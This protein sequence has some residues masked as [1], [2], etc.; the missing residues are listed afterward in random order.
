M[1][2]VYLGNYDGYDVIIIYGTVPPLGYAGYVVAGYDFF[3]N[4]GK[5]A[6]YA[7]KD[8]EITELSNG[9]KEGLFTEDFIAKIYAD[10]PHKGD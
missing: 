8:G 4:Q 6:L 9:Y 10:W 1:P 5:C 3:C 7:Y 2:A